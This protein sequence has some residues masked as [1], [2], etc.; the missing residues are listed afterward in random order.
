MSRGL[1]ARNASAPRPRRASACGRTLET[2]TSAPA[3]S[4]RSSSRS[5]ACLASRVTLCL[6]RFKLRYTAPMPVGTE[7]PAVLKTSPSGGLHLDD[8]GAHVPQED[9]KSVV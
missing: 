3:A 8:L 9:R 1:R 6:L 5:A 4:L 7:G 2:K